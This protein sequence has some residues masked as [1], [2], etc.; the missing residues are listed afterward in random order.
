[1]LGAILPSQVGCAESIMNREHITDIH[2]QKQIP[3]LGSW[4]VIICGSG[5]SAIAAA[6]SAARQ[7][8]KVLLL[9]RYG[10]VGGNLTLG[11]VSPIMGGVAPGTFAQEIDRLLVAHNGGTAIDPERAKIELTKLL[12]REDIEFRLQTPIFDTV[13]EGKTIAGVLASTQLGPAFFNGKRVID[14]T[15][16]GQIAFLSGAEMMMGRP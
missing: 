13:M 14:C 4:D 8:I 15:G 6:V 16:D 5:P 9:E 3:C 1:M 11:N 7:G 2:Y 12:E 10:V